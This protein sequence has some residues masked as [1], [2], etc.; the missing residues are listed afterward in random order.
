MGLLEVVVV[1]VVVVAVGV[2]VGVGVGGGGAAAA[3]VGDGDIGKVV[4]E[5]FVV[6]YVVDATAV[7]R[8]GDT[9]AVFLIAAAVSD[10]G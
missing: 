3:A 5:A 2:G 8:R 9:M 7:A 1:V 10:I 6:A 4:V